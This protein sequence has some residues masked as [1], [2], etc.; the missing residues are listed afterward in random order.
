[1]ADTPLP[2]PDDELLY[3]LVGSGSLRLLYGLLHRRM[4]N[5]P[6]VSEAELFAADALGA[7]ATELASLL[8]ELRRHFRI[9]E[10]VIDGSRRYLLTGWAASRDVAE[11][12]LSARLEAQVLLP[13]RCYTC[14]KTPKEDHVRLV[15]DWR[16]P[17]AWGGETSLENLQPLCERCAE[18]KRQ[19]FASHDDEASAIRAA[20]EHDEPQKRIGELLL[21]FAPREVRSDL[22]EIVA[23]AQ[24]YQDDWPRRVRDLRFLGW[25]YD[26]RKSG[27]EGARIWSYYKLTK[28]AA[29]P[30]DIPAAIKAEALRR[31]RTRPVPTPT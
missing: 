28:H 25:D 17:R 29:W 3:N 5:P 1:V 12:G 18:G 2:G 11:P 8:S 14:G 24:A 26:V 22:I 30:E 23:G 20:M 27:Q 10:P 19:Y 6:R 16:I 9:D 4:S 21:A 31:K 15:V 13:Q 7:N